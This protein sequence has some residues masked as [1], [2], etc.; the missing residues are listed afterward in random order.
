MDSYWHQKDRHPAPSHIGSFFGFRVELGN[1][2]DLLGRKHRV[3][4]PFTAGAV[5][6]VKFGAALLKPLDL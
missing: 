3:A 5:E 4:H 6:D 1:E 2:L